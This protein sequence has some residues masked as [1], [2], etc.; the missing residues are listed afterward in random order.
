MRRLEI[1]KED[2]SSSN[3]K[4][5]IKYI[6]TAVALVALLWV[7]YC[8]FSQH[9]SSNPERINNFVAE[10]DDMNKFRVP[11]VAGLFYPANAGD[12]DSQVGKYLSS[13]TSTHGK[14]PKI[15]VVPHAGY[16]YSAQTAAKAYSLLTPYRDTIRNV[17]LVGP[18]HHVALKG[19]ALSNDDYFT[20][21]LGKIE[22]NKALNAELSVQPGFQ[23]NNAAHLKEHSLEVQLPFL[24]K[25]L[26][27]FTITPIVYGEADPQEL[28]NALAPFL[29]QP[30]TLI[31]F[32]ADLSHYYTYDQ[33]K[34]IDDQTKTL[35]ENKIPLVE[36]HMSCGA[37]GINA[38]VILAQENYLLPKLLDIVNS[39]D[40]T[41]DKSG[42]VGY[43][44]WSFDTPEKAPEK[45]PHNP[46]EQEVEN[47]RSFASHH[48]KELM[49]ISRLSLEE[50]VLKNKHFKPHRDDYPDVLFNKGA[51]FVT[52]EKHGELRGCIGS[53]M[54]NQSIAYDIA[55]NSYSAAMEDNRFS[56]I[57]PEEL[58]D[59]KI[60][61]SLLSG[62]EPTTYNSEE[63]LLTKIVKGVDGIVIRDGDRQGVFLPSVWKQLPDPQEFLNNLKLK[64]GM[65]PTYW[66]NK[67]KVYRFRVVEI[68][69]DED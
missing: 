15:L 62:F 7:N 38:A 40:V 24:Q 41:G 36:D 4:R 2:K 34:Q 13:T 19:V 53:L 48:G 45:T 10:V 18:S 26:K 11:A 20:T 63:D 23:Y 52:L 6:L 1:N 44:A 16:M 67:I 69:K 55:L 22:V 29:K 42:V 65:S 39:G 57:E 8:H 31:I 58:K 56:Q 43:G 25:V 54:P 59:I 14:Q 3:Y 28:A 46:L 60:S 68:S 51:A 35:V 17:V 49:N 61:I 30:E 64:A 9:I 37:T 50:A 5:N 12:L 27:N 21:P 47:L 66:S 32:S 33:A